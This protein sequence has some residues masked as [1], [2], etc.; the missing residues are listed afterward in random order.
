MTTNYQ[1]PSLPKGLTC[2][3]GNSGRTGIHETKD[4]SGT[5]RVRNKYK[6]N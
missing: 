2:T 4:Y 6:R 3:K 5:E 1:I